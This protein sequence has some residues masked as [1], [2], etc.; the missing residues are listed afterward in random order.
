MDGG[1]RCARRHGRRAP[2]VLLSAS[3]L[4][5]RRGAAQAQADYTGKRVTIVIGYGVGGTYD[6]YAQLFSRHLGA[7]L[8]GHPTTVVQTMPGAG[9][10]KM[11]NEAATRAIADGTMIFI[12]PDTMVTTQL[13]DASGHFYDARRFQYIG[14]ADQQNV[15]WVV[16][17]GTVRSVA[18]MKT[19]EVF[20]GHS[21]KGST[22]YSIPAVAREL[23]GL[24]V[25]LIGGFEGSRDTIL[26]M[27]RGEIDGTLQAWQSWQ[28]AR[29]TWFEGSDPY[30]VPILQVGVAADPDGPKVPLLSELAAPQDKAV[31]GL[32]DTIG[33]LGRSL[34]APPATPAAAVAALRSAFTAMVA[35]PGFRHD[36]DGIG[37]RIAPKAGDA[38]QSAI[39]NAID[40][41]DPTSVARARTIVN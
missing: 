39:N 15:F 7:F 27:E 8:P 28:Q 4:S 26:A 11:L 12:P 36:A 17:K 25:K 33:L 16:R 13:L 3:R 38:L 6:Q 29:P 31:A 32:F 2:C 18:D 24:K 41:T 14:T 35:D 1:T 34:A 40:R 37:L 30:G 9:G 20:M 5:Q 10:V 19:R 21:G 22:G 23:L